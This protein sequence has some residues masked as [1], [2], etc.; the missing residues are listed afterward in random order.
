M[1]I[2]NSMTKIYRSN[3]QDREYKQE[4]YEKAIL[5]PDRKIDTIPAEFRTVD[6]YVRALSVAKTEED[7]NHVIDIMDEDISIYTGSQHYNRTI[8]LRAL[9]ELLFE[10]KK[11]R[12]KK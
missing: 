6:V 3:P 2:D 4:V 8:T 12:N 10:C 5:N 11:M 1:T 9:Q 7:K